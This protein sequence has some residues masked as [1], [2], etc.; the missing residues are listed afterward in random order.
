MDY[1]SIEIDLV[2]HTD[3]RGMSD[4]NLKLSSE[5]AFSAKAY[6]VSKGI[7]GSRI[8]AIGKGETKLRNECSD[9]V[10]CNEE[11]HQFN[12]RTEVVIRKMKEASSVR[13]IQAQ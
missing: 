12:S 11:Q 3:S 10:D 9:G 5:R 8:D 4:Y 7:D 2:A 13:L 6:L 1:P